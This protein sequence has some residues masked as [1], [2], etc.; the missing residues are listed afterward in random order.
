MKA[1]RVSN[2]NLS[3]AEEMAAARARRTAQTAAAI[4]DARVL[5]VRTVL[6]DAHSPED[7][8]DTIQRFYPKLSEEKKQE[9]ADR[10]QANGVLL[11]VDPEEG[12]WTQEVSTETSDEDAPQE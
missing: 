5:A 7:V 10:I 9:V 4:R 6:R 11:A 2:E 3:L 1:I 8:M 12:E